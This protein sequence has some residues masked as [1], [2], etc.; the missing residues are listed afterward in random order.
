MAQPPELLMKQIHAWT[1]EQSRHQ[2]ASQ[3][4]YLFH[5]LK[6]V[7]FFSVLKLIDRGA[8]DAYL[9]RV[10]PLALQVCPADE[11]DTLRTSLVGM[12]DSLVIG[13]STSTVV[14]L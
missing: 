4:D 9:D 1:L 12:R 10:V 13:G 8:L 7:Y 3:S 11:R 5:A 14:A 6:K 2:S